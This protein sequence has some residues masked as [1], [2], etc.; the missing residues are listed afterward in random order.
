MIS[1]NDKGANQRMSRAVAF[2][3]KDKHIMLTATA[4]NS[5][6]QHYHSQT[7]LKIVVQSESIYQADIDFIR[8]LPALNHQPNVSVEFWKPPYDFMKRVSENFST[9]TQL[10][11]MV[12]WRLFL[13]YYF[14]TY[15]QIVYLDNDVLVTTDINELFDQLTEDDVIGG[16]LDYSNAIYHTPEQVKRFFLPNLS[17]YINGG[18][19]VMNT[20]AYRDFVSADRMIA[21]INK[22]NYPLGDQSILNITFFNHIH[23]LPWRFN[24]QFDR[25]GLKEYEPLTPS[26][27]HEIESQLD[28]PGIIH[29]IHNN[30]F[31]S[32]WEKF[33]PSTPWEQLWWETF[34]DVMHKRVTS[35]AEQLKQ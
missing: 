19:L 12:L 27:V 14:S 13:P 32:P 1:K 31:W 35:S 16:V 21:Q 6:I 26:R 22:R 33:S 34:A 28:Q 25:R 4:I 30:H 3:V 29:F 8:T 23:V 2:A 18:V 10:P 20:K 17:Q 24:R 5:L 9:G 11:K 7:P 15:D